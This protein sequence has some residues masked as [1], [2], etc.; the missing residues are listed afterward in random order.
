MASSA[1][2][3]VAAATAAIAEPAPPGAYVPQP[4]G[5]IRV[6]IPGATPADTVVC[7]GFSNKPNYSGG[8]ITG[9]GGILSCSP[10]APSACASETTLELWLSGPQMW[11]AVGASPRQ[12]LCPPPAR[13]T[14]ARAE[15]TVQPVQ[16]TYRTET[17]VTVVYGNS[18]SDA[19]P[20][21][22]LNLSCL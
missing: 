10:H 3:L 14:T 12:T 15:C 2:L 5:E 20:S 18:A 11:T 8:V 17:L 22:Q 1:L 13:S 9:T 19:Y 21:D 7:A 4:T 16:Y 6:G